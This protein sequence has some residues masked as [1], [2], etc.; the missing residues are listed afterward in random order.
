LKNYT[1]DMLVEIAGFLYLSSGGKK[2]D[3]VERISELSLDDSSL[4]YFVESFLDKEA[5]TAL[6]WLLE[7]A[8]VRPW[9]EMLNQFSDG[10]IEAQ[11]WFTD[12]TSNIIWDLQM[13][14]LIFSGT[15]DGKEVA[16]IPADLRPL[17]SKIIN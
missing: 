14:G 9:Q 12:D 15:L 8:G 11:I 4:K 17:L 13:A 2:N 10:S 16:F 3:L 5:S 1:N 7:T 6:R